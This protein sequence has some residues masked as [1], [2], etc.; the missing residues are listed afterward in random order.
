MQ[1][2]IF[3]VQKSPVCVSNASWDLNLP[4]DA[5]PFDLCIQVG[6]EKKQNS[7]Y[8]LVLEQDFNIVTLQ[9]SK[10]YLIKLSLFL[11]VV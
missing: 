2:F 7:N 8:N 5:C 4:L 9:I 1:I 3:L 10:S 11:A 6:H